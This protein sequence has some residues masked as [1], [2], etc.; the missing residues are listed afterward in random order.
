MSTS[1]GLYVRRPGSASRWTEK[2]YR[3]RTAAK[4]EACK[5][6]ATAAIN[7]PKLVFHA[8]LAAKS[9][10]FSCN[11]AQQE[12]M[13]KSNHRHGDRPIQTRVLKSSNYNTPLYPLHTSATNKRSEMPPSPF[14]CLIARATLP[15]AARQISPPGVNKPARLVAA[16]GEEQ[17]RSWGICK[18][19]GARTGPSP[20]RSR[21]RHD[22]A[23]QRGVSRPQLHM[24]AP[25]RVAA[26]A[27]YREGCAVLP[28][29]EGRDT[30]AVTALKG[31]RRASLGFKIVSTLTFKTQT[32]QP[33][34][35][36]S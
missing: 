12:L 33:T 18:S 1:P 21:D 20:A 30:L 29:L 4:T 3:S 2:V 31:I 22:V 26:T 17:R 14:Q 15:S 36:A 9:V 28:E 5:K 10:L 6:I 35:R 19:G 13:H 8:T 24:T 32:I 34:P 25:V 23:R 27:I 7:K 16:H 11:P